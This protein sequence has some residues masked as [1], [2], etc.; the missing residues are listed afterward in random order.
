MQGKPP[1]IHVA[2]PA[3]N[4]RDYIGRT[5]EC[6]QK[7]SFGDFHTWICVNQPESFHENPEKQHICQN[8]AQT[9][10]LLKNYK[11][12]NLH[13]IDKSSKGKGWEEGKLGVGMARKTIMD[14]IAS[15]ASDQDI[16][17]SL[18]ADTLFGENYLASVCRIFLQNPDAMGLSNPYYHPLGDDNKLNRAMLRYEIYMRY[19]ALNMR[20]TGTP[21]YFTPLGSAMAAPVDAYKKI[22]GLTAKKSGEDFYFLQKLAKAGQVLM[23]NTEIIYPGNRL[24]NRV[25]FGTGP[26]MIKG[27]SGQWSAYPL[28]NPEF[29]KEI[30]KTISIFPDLFHGPHPTP[31][32]N[33]LSNH[34]RC[35]DIFEPLRKNHK[36]PDRFVKACHEKVDGLRILQYLKVQHEQNPG[37]DEENL[38]TFLTE[39][40]PDN[41]LTIEL[42][43]LNFSASPIDILNKIRKFLF[44]TEL[45][46]QKE[47]AKQI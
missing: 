16:I 44:E 35:P 29:F 15:V 26:A 47:D 13:I 2:L 27:L 25:F 41:N 11:L 18:D 9:L 42:K 24:S 4:E 33:F 36:N 5:L 12:P 1:T 39:N 8:N 37:C 32:D 10:S 7:Q 46:F 20:F 31:M 45:K 19:Y 30:K 22:N 38:A 23:Y 6:L 43:E 14:T 3:M 28:F 21:Y 34:F 40:F 17:L